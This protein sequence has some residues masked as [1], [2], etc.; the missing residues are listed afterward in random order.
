[1]FCLRGDQVLFPGPIEPGHSLEVGGGGKKNI[2][3]ETAVTSILV[4]RSKWIRAVWSNIISLT[5]VCL[6]IQLNSDT[7]YPN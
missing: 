7:N 4:A 1:M 3:R 6:T 2:L 5:I